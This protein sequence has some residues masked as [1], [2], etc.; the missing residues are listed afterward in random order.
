MLKGYKDKLAS[1]GIWGAGLVLVSTGIQALAN[2]FGFTVGEADITEAVN[3]STQIVQG[4]G[5]FLALYGRIKA[6]KKVW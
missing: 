2:H 3:L 4:F 5:G 1:K 6:T